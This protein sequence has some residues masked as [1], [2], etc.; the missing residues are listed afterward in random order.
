[1]TKSVITVDA[2]TS[3]A[4]RIAQHLEKPVINVVR[5]TTSGL[6]AGP[7]IVEL[8]QGVTQEGQIG[9]RVKICMKLNVRM[10]WKT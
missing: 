9:P 4:I 1:M 10:T 7:M 2:A 8:S 3:G 5:K 6:Y